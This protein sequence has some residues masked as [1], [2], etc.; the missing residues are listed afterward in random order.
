M[1]SVYPLLPG[2]YIL[3]PST[4]SVDIYRFGSLDSWSYLLVHHGYAECYILA[5]ASK[6]RYVGVYT[7]L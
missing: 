7:L 2:S 1:R 5:I 6:I 4:E 3:F